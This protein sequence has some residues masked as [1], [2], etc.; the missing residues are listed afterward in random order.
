MRRRGVVGNERG[1]TLV[2]LGIVMAIIAILAA[3]AYPTYKGMK[4]RAEL[5]EAKSLLQE[6]RADVW[7]YYLEHGWPADFASG[8][9]KPVSSKW[10]FTI[11]TGS[12]K[13]DAID[14]VYKIE[15]YD[16]VIGS[17]GT[18]EVTLWLNADGQAKL[19]P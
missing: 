6:I 18:L 13:I 3:V 2:E 1:F 15:A 14:Y 16:G 11:G 9:D 17:G 19:D 10:D 7:A 5:S 12:K 8:I 4:E